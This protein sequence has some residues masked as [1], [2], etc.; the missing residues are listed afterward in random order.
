MRFWRDLSISKKLYIVIGIMAVLIAGELL[1]L[2]FAM[3]TLSAVRAFVGGESLWT[4]GQ[5]N[6][7][8]HL[9]RYGIT[10]NEEDFR[11]FLKYLEAPEGDHAA[12]LELQKPNPDLDIVRAGFRQGNIHPE[13]ID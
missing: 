10:R 5:K 13:D 1:T 6:A 2:T 8:I 11:A 12:R 4:K 3:S 7:A 9:Q